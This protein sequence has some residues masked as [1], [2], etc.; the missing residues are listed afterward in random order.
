MTI[1]E[2]KYKD[3]KSNRI[4][5]QQFITEMKKIDDVSLLIE[6][7]STINPIIKRLKNC[8]IIN[9]FSS[10][11]QQSTIEPVQRVE[12]SNEQ[13][14]SDIYVTKVDLPKCIE[15]I[16]DDKKYIIGGDYINSFKTETY[17]G[18]EM[19]DKGDEE[20]ITDIV[21]SF[22]GDFSDCEHD[23]SISIDE[24]AYE[25]ENCYK[26]ISQK[27]T[28]NEELLNFLDGR[29]FSI[30]FN[31]EIIET[32]D[33]DLATQKVI[34]NLKKNPTY[35]TDF[36]QKQSEKVSKYSYEIDGENLVDKKNPMKKISFKL[37][38][39]ILK[40]LEE[41][42]V[43][44]GES[45]TDEFDLQ[46]GKKTETPNVKLVKIIKDLFIKIQKD[47]HDNGWEREKYDMDARNQVYYLVFKKGKSKI[48]Y[49]ILRHGGENYNI[50]YDGRHFTYNNVK[51]SYKQFLNLISSKKSIESDK[52]SNLVEKQKD[53]IEKLIEDKDYRVEVTKGRRDGN[54][55]GQNFDYRIDVVD[56]ND[57]NIISYSLFLTSGKEKYSLTYLE[58]DKTNYKDFTSMKQAFTKVVSLL[59]SNPIKK[60]KG[61]SD[62]VKTDVE[63]ALN[64]DKKIEN[65]LYVISQYKEGNDKG[66][67]KL[68]N[69]LV[70][71]LY[72][73]QEIKDMIDS[74]YNGDTDEIK[75]SLL[76]ILKK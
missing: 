64:K 21:L 76:T 35:Y 57:K 50:I 39:D 62:E 1:V 74:E 30:G 55:I 56:S 9:E 46:R 5:P 72:K 67:L 8:K 33:S 51:D 73:N 26:T 43:S 4:T 37:H 36:L 34:K 69:F 58:N 24:L 31:I 49:D 11:I 29:E 71:E 65:L 18:D 20:I 40:N 68:L 59:S 32:K 27:S 41:V 19:I 28:L 63:G 3:L 75:K 52:Y 17:E 25:K 15:L 12:F 48:V 13:P 60:S 53:Y 7:L 6:G 10:N 14:T 66:Y 44:S 16:Y 45:G 22:N 42:E 23:N 70:K 2:R 38:E 47:A 61:V 54:E